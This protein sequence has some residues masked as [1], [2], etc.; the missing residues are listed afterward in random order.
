MFV[1]QSCAAL[2][3]HFLKHVMEFLNHNDSPAVLDIY[4][5]C[6]GEQGI[7]DAQASRHGRLAVESRMNPVFVYDPRR[8]GDLHGRFS[9]DGNPDED[10]DWAT[11]TIEYVEDG[12]T[13]LMEQPLTP[14]DFA[15]SEGRFKKQFRPLAAGAAGVPMHEYIDLA[16]AERAGK[17]PFV[18]STRD[19]KTLTKMEASQTIVHLVRERRKNWRTLQVLAG[20]D[21]DEARRRPSQ[22]GGGSAAPVQGCAGGA[23]ILDRLDRARDVRA[24]RI[25]GRSGRGAALR[26]D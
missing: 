6:Q 3:G 17:T 12:V 24:R 26:R 1:V 8:S 10:K 19:D 20:L 25:V 4:T 15:L 11:G 18:W 5:P 9:L 7:A 16:E 21:V 22:R 23:R 13:K 2:P 14:A